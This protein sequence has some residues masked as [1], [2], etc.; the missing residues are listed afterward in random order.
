MKEA[1]HVGLMEIGMPLIFAGVFI[2]IV[3]RALSK[4]NLFPKNHPYL[5]ESVHHD[6]GP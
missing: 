3:L 2:F 1:G 6:V 5:Q 4:A